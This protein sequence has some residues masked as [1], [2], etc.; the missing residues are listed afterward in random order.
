MDKIPKI[1]R[2][3]R[4]YHDINNFHVA[5]IINL[6]LFPTILPSSL[7]ISIR[8]C[9]G[10]HTGTGPFLLQDYISKGK[11]SKIYIIHIACIAKLYFN[12]RNCSIK[13]KISLPILAIPY[14]H[15]HQNHRHLSLV[16]TKLGSTT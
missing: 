9:F 14:F 10:Y 7:L 16:P 12:E 4:L 11:M 8:I 2:Q 6:V 1:I 13:E 5:L 3:I 15:S